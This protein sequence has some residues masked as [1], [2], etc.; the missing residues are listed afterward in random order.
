[1]D[2][3]RGPSMPQGSGTQAS[4]IDIFPQGE[5]A[6]LP[7]LPV[8]HCH[9]TILPKDM[10]LHNPNR[11]ANNLAAHC[12]SRL[13]VEILAF[14]QQI[15]IHDPSMPRPRLRLGRHDTIRHIGKSAGD[16]DLVLCAEIG[17]PII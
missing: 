9:K 16:G 3:R 4:T 1:M 2:R 14:A 12:T 8:G 10:S 13:I 11:R 5:I 15:D 17:A 6:P 7:S